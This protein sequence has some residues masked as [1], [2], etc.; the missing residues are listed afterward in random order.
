MKN[1]PKQ[2]IL[3]VLSIIG[4]ENDKDKFASEFV[5]LCMQKAV[6]NLINGMPQDKQDQVLQRLSLTTPD[7]W[8]TLLSEYVPEENLAAAIKDTSSLI[9]QDYIKEIEPTLN[10]E[11]RNKLSQYLSSQASISA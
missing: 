11:Q 2:I 9:F 4:Y 5:T 6:S 3:E 8:G 1:D 10:D 7:S